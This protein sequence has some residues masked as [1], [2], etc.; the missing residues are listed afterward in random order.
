MSSIIDER[1]SDDH[2]PELLDIGSCSLHVIHGAFRKGFCQTDWGIDSVLR[3]LY[4]LFDKSPANREDFAEITG[5]DVFPLQFCGHRWLEDKKVADRALQIWPHITKYISETLK[6]PKYQIPASSSFA[7]VRSA[8]HDLLT[9]A[10]L[11]FF[12]STASVMLPY[13]QVFQSDAPLGP[14]VISELHTLLETLMGKFVKR[15]ELEK[16]DSPSKM[17]KFDV[18]PS[19]HH[20]AAK[21]IDVGFAAKTM[22]EKLIKDKKVSELQVLEFR[23]GCEAVL[24]GTV[25]KIQERSPLKFALARKLTSLDLRLIASSPETATRMFQQATKHLIDAQW[26]TSGEGDTILA[27]YRRFGSEAR[28]YN[29]EKFSSFRY[30]DT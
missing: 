12:A 21:D 10:K 13:L 16:L 26:I 8:V 9:P 18:S 20:V 27:Q 4:N 1:Q 30:E 17:V 2:Y 25:S 11:A 23:K 24:V 6:K 7:T 14:F 28:K 5:T 19:Q 3:A 29:K 22:I 15:T